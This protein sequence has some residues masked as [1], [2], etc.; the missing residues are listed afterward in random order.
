MSNGYFSIQGYQQETALVGR[1]NLGPFNVPFS[2]V[3][4]AQQY[5]ITSATQTI[6]VPS[7]SYGVAIIPPIGA[8]PAGVTMKFKTNSGD[9]GDYIS[10]EQPSVIEWDVTNSHVPAD[11]YLVVAGG[12]IVVGVQF[13]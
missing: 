1:T 4:D 10:T 7:G 13:L 3:S 12:N 6:A 8:P 9:S 5:S 2:A 11:I